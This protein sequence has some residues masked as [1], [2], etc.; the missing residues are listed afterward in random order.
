V[1]YQT[2]TLFIHRTIKCPNDYKFPKWLN[3]INL[4]NS[5]IPEFCLDITS[6]EN[7]KKIRIYHISQFANIKTNRNDL[8]CIFENMDITVEHLI[9]LLNTASETKIFSEVLIFSCKVSGKRNCIIDNVLKSNKYLN[10]TVHIK[11]TGLYTSYLDIGLFNS[12]FIIIEPNF[13]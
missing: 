7:L 11:R 9:K 13:L 2:K 12:Q 6:A 3:Q 5:K 10:M 8:M 1:K 4:M